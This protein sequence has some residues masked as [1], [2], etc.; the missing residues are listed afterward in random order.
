MSE[1][2]L[3][4]AFIGLADVMKRLRKDC[5]WDRKQTHASLRRYLIEECHE[6]LAALDAGD[7]EELRGELGDLLFQVWFH[8]EVASERDGGFDLADVLEGVTRKLVRRHPHVYGDAEARDASA[9]RASW[10]DLKRAEGR[11]RTLE[12]VPPSLPALLLAQVL[13][14]KAAGVGFDWPDTEGPLAKIREELGELEE[15]VR[16]APPD[17]GATPEMTHELGDLLFALVN[18]A[19]HLEINA[20]DALREA[21]HRF[22]SRFDHVEDAVL[23][24]GEDM[25]D[26][27]LERLDE[28]WDAA[29]ESGL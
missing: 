24:R 5:P 23:A 4:D 22:R 8:A 15:A 17:D 27:P 10:E 28:L 29:K 12:S 3:R 7:D 25:R 6:V 13:Q 1:D 14:E 19:R 21:S 26:L 2:R 18:T 9:V 20:E 11:T 16:E